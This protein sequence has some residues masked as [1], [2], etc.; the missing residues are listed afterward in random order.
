MADLAAQF[1]DIEP[2]IRTDEAGTRYRWG[3]DIAA[4]VLPDGRLGQFA[5]AGWSR[6]EVEA[7]LR[8]IGLIA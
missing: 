2:N 8:K 4:I 3:D 6:T 5:A 1:A 7:A